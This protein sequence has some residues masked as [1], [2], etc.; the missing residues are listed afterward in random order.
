M[1]KGYLAFVLHAH[2]P[3][4]R[5]PEYDRFLEERWL[6]EAITE[7]YIPLIQ[8]FD[9]LLSEHIPCRLTLSIS[10]SL[11]AML[12]D[13]L[14][15]ER[16]EA[17]LNQLIELSVRELARTQS[18]PRVHHLAEFYHRFFVAGL[19]TFVNRCQRRLATAFRH[20]HE[21]GIINLMTT[22][23]T[24]GLLPLLAGQPKAVNA[25]L[26]IGLNYFQSVFGFR[27][28]GLWLPECGYYPGLDAVL[29]EQN[30]RFFIVES[31]GIEHAS[32]TPFNG[33][34]TPLY[35]PSGV[36]AF[37]RDRGSTKQVWSAQEGFP[38]HPDYRE[39]YRDIGHE[40]DFDYIQPYIAD[41]VRVDTGIKYRRITGPTVWKEL[42]RPATARQQAEHHAEDF[43][44]QR[45][46]D[47]DYLNSIMDATP[48]VLAPFDAEL[49]GHWWFEGPH[50]LECV[51][52]KTVCHQEGLAL[53]TPGYYLTAHPDH[54]TA[55]PCTSTWGNQGF[56]DTWLNGKTDWIYPQLYTCGQRM[57]ALANGQGREEV[58][59]FK[60][61]ALNQ[62]VR[63]LLLAQ[64]SDWPFII[65]NGTAAE[66]A[67]RRV[68]DHV[69][70]FHYLA[71]ALEQDALDAERLAALEWLDNPFPN[72]DYRLFQS[73]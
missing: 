52:R 23:A 24:H 54:Q 36:A 58:S 70:R 41:G 29:A 14:L 69:A 5:H 26:V 1:P 22:T 25:Q 44:S 67:T 47:I 48:I 33:V 72:A 30:I 2:L 63:E 49:F 42:Y 57:E 46:A 28:D 8:V 27:P 45:R 60:R 55:T 68:K 12:E 66:Y 65:N 39:F 32:I 35:T 19:D 13:A 51:I 6:F 38:G 4:V 73:D 18:E 9:R 31:H 37:G 50:W 7:S 10:P 43:L 21:Q 59:E 56:F 20:F 62:C 16:Y 3:Y 11:L 53:T 34:Y 40:L 71:D 15:L 61:R 17:H 64:S